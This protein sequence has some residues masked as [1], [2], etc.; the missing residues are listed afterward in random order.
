MEQIKNN[1][2]KWIYC[3]AIRAIRTMGQTF[4]AICATNEIVTIGSIDWRF[5]GSAVLMAGI[6]SIMTSVAGLPEVE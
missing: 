6:L 1:T 5:V 4:I 2:K 3:S